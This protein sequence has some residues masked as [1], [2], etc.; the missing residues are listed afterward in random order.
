MKVALSFIAGGLANEVPEQ[1][2]TSIAQ[3]CQLCHA[4]LHHFKRQ[5]TDLT[6]AESFIYYTDFHIV[7]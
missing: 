3:G 1:D 7:L 4:P 2:L 5:S 6:P